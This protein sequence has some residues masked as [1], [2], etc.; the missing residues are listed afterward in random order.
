MGDAVDRAEAGHE[1]LAGDA[2]D[3]AAGKDISQDS[4]SGGVV[5]MIVGGNEDVKSER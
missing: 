3:L 5:G 1:G 2:D 4:Q